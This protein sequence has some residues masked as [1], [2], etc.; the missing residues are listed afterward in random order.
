ML[1]VCGR[2]LILSWGTARYKEL[3]ACVWLFSLSYTY[4]WQRLKM[5]I[6]S[7]LNKIF[8][9]VM[10]NIGATGHTKQPQK[11]RTD[12]SVRKPEPV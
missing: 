9:N 8:T 1:R 5:D 3:C 4:R 2:T 10:N 7:P 11:D 6:R 12:R